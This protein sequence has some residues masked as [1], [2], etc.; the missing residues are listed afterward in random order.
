MDHQLWMRWWSPPGSFPA[1]LQVQSI[2][3]GVLP[4]VL[5]RVKQSRLELSRVTMNDVPLDESKVLVE[6]MERRPRPRTIKLAHRLR[7][8]IAS[9]LLIRSHKQD[10]KG[11]IP[12]DREDDWAADD[13]E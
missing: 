9:P 3:L 11:T 8:S 2:Q 7:C 10:V 1:R 13:S 6:R 12:L 5:R 4:V